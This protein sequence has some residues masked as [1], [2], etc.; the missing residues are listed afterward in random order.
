MAVAGLVFF[1]LVYRKKVDE[2]E[3]TILAEW[4][5]QYAQY[6]RA[7]PRWLPL[8]RPYASAHGEW[9]WEGIKASREWK[10]TLWVII[11]LVGVYFWEEWVLEREVFEASEAVKQVALLSLASILMLSDGVVELVRRRRRVPVNRSRA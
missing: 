10:T 9:R 5:E 4:G 11:G 1:L 2:E 3:K 7:V 8:L 6:Q